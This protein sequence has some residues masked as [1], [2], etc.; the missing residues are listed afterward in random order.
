MQQLWGATELVDE[1]I[2]DEPVSPLAPRIAVRAAQH[3]LP[4]G[5][6]AALDVQ[7]RAQAAG[8]RLDEVLDEVDRVRDEVGSPPLAAPIGQ[9]VA[10][11]ALLNVL[12]ANRYWTMVDELRDLVDGRVRPH[13]GPDRRRAGARRRALRRRAPTT[14]RVD[15]DT[16]RDEAGGL[17]A[18]EEELL[19]LALFGEEAEPLLRA[20]RE[21]V[22]R[23]GVA[24]GRRASTRSAQSGS[25]RSSGSSRRPASARSRSRRTACASACAARP[26]RLAAAAAAAPLRPCRARSRPTRRRAARRHARPRREPDGRHVLPRA[27][28]RLA[29][30]RR[31]GRRGR[32]RARRSASSRR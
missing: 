7:L 13:A 14:R 19:L 10:S 15:L 23:R 17:A 24:R 31:G 26:S 11:Q 12:S 25:A 5:L 18:S 16:L 9:I 29:A 32:S 28:A 30:V 2:G 20:I 3:K 6:V 1:H 27:G 8:D 21:R 4:V 22:G